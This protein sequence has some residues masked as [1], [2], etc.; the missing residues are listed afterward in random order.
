[1]A[2]TYTLNRVDQRQRMMSPILRRFSRFFAVGASGVLVNMGVLIL[3]T[4]SF[5][6]PYAISSLLAIELSILS[7]FLLNNAWTWADRRSNPF[8]E[9][10]FKYHLVAGFSALLGNW[11][12]LILLTSLF[13]VDYRAANLAGIAAGMV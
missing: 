13:R 5:G 9:R 1:M 10:L 8:V 7:N 12:L 2:A 3:L 6:V 4:E 11:C